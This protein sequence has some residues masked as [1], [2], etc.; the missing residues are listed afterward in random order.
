MYYNIN[1]LSSRTQHILWFHLSTKTL[2]LFYTEIQ[3]GCRVSASRSLCEPG[4]VLTPR[5]R[6][7]QNPKC[8]EN[9]SELCLWSSTL[10]ASRERNL[11]LTTLWLSA[12][13]YFSTENQTIIYNQ[14]FQHLSQ[15]DGLF[16]FV[17]QYNLLLLLAV[18]GNM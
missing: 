3:D 15:Y 2:A 1:A 10:I 12:V 13:K 9:S 14:K 18:C 6:R 11:N 16:Y 17:T 7:C 8:R 5:T 4:S